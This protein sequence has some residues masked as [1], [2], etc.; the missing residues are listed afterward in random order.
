MIFCGDIVVD[1]NAVCN[2]HVNLSII[3][4]SAPLLS[5][6][7]LSL[8]KDAIYRAILAH[9]PFDKVKCVLGK[10]TIL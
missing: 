6:L 9:I 1:G 4:F 5:S 8:H 7:L 10:N 2:L 3:H